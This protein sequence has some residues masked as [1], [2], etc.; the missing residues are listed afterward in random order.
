M[1]N[2]APIVSEF[3]AGQTHWPRSHT[4]HRPVQCPGIFSRENPTTRSDLFSLGV[5]TYQMLTG[6]L[7][8]GIK[9]SQA[10]SRLAQSKLSYDSALAPDR[11]IPAWIDEVIK[12]A[13]QPNPQ[14]RYQGLSEFIFWPTPTEWNLFKQNSPT[15][16]RTQST[17][18]LEKC[19][20]S[21]HPC[22][23]GIVT[24]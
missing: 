10:R 22:C 17:G 20:F 24:A 21:S 8:Y 3:I 12:K 13:I 6:K 1:T 15:I 16:F 5:I 18:F 14:K 23:G 11:E 2:K 4:W 9:V 19:F 7:P